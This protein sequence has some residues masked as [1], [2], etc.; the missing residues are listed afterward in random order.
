MD[1]NAETLTRI[2]GPIV[3][4]RNMLFQYTPLAPGGLFE[5]MDSCVVAGG[6]WLVVGQGG[7]GMG[8]GGSTR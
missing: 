1:C 5:S 4:H 7:K 2:D 6:W 3:V 8:A